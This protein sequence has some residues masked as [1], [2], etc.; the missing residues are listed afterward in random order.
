M[1]AHETT[2]VPLV[3]LNRGNAFEALHRGWAVVTDSTGRILYQAGEPATPIYSRS[4]LKPL[5]V[6]P[7]LLTGTAQ[8]YQFTEPELTIMCSSHGGEPFHCETV[9]TL[10]A[11]GGLTLEHLQCGSHL[12]LHAPSAL[13]LQ[14]QDIA[15]TALHNNCSGKHT[16]MLLN[17]QSQG[18]PLNDYLQPEHP[19][20]QAIREAIQTVTGLPPTALHMG[21]DG[22]SAPNYSFPLQAMATAY[23][24]LANPHDLPE[25]FAVALR[26]I[27]EALIHYPLY[28]AGHE[29]LDSALMQACPGLVAKSGASGLLAIAVR[30]PNIGMAIKIENGSKDWL[31]L[32]AISLLQK[33]A[34][35]PQ[36]LPAN[37]QSW[38][39]TLIFNWQGHVVGQAQLLCS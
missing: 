39:E 24:R 31:P 4:A 28:L 9:A 20:Q 23:A 36:R 6:L 1:T 10:L 37:L 26:Q 5:Q 3:R 22:C 35:L 19:G 29:R 25:P 13:A 17:A 38:A 27:Y 21:I 30:E 34:I 8:Q 11:K 14:R 7:L 33:W 18:W 16:G 12:P 32:M 2:S 15:P